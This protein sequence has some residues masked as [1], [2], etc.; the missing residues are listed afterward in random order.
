[1]NV[2]SEFEAG[3]IVGNNYGN[4]YNSY[5]AAETIECWSAA[6]AKATNNYYVGGIAA[7]NTGEISN[8]HSVAEL[9]KGNGNNPINYYGGLVGMNDGTLE[10]SFWTVNP[11]EDA[12]GAGE[13]EA[14]NCAVMST[15]TSTL[16]NTNAQ[17]LATEIGYEL[18]GWTDGDDD[19]PVFDREDRAIMDIDNIDLNVSLYPNPASDFV[20]VECENMQ[21]VMVYN[22]FG[23]LVI[24]NEVN[25]NMADINVSGF[26]AGIYTVRIV[27]ANGSATRNVVVK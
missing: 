16:M 12:I 25:D 4:I 2:R 13:E 5:C 6:P 23:Q 21:R 17:A 1:M 3:G 9:V 18:F 22:M 20:K 10:N 8:C 27:T 14:V 24:D 15:T 26:A 11:I 19:Y 7:W